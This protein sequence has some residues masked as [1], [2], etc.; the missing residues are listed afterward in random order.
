MFTPKPGL[1]D[2]GEENP[3]EGIENDVGSVLA[4]YV[5]TPVSTDDKDSSADGSLV[6]FFEMNRHEY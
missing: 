1:P 5:D 3:L 6:L 2:D 4:T